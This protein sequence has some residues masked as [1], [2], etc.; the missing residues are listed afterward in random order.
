MEII[1]TTIF[2]FICSFMYCCVNNVNNVKKM[3]N[4]FLSIFLSICIV[5]INKLMEPYILEESIEGLN[6]LC[7]GLIGIVFVL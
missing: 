7:D 6:I 4:L 2:I 1:S 3:N 5:G